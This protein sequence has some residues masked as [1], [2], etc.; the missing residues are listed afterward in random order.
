MLSDV[1]LFQCDKRWM[2]LKR[3]VLSNVNMFTFPRVETDALSLPT[4]NPVHFQFP[5]HMAHKRCQKSTL[6]AGAWPK[7]SHA[8]PNRRLSGF[9]YGK[10]R[11]FCDFGLCTLFSKV[12]LF[13]L[14]E[15]F[16]GPQIC[17]TCW[18]LGLCPDP[19][20]GA[21]D[22][23]PDPLVSW[24]EGQPSP[25]ATPHGAFGTSILSVAPNV[26][27]CQCPCMLVLLTSCSLLSVIFCRR[28]Y[29][30]EFASGRAP[31]SRLHRK[32]FQTVTEDIS[33]CASLVW[34]A[35]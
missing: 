4:L 1:F 21:H 5:L 31:R 22:A 33:F 6:L 8:H 2:I 26:Q 29:R 13:F 18:R 3:T 30:L 14:P 32:H 11:L 34:T 17:Q 24:G 15:V 20:G 7:G 16:C 35:R 10:K 19:A 23:P 28:S 12:T 25:I 9:L 27:F